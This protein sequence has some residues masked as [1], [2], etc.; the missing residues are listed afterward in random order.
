MDDAPV[1][2][3]D[4]EA[5]ELQEYAL[6]R[7]ANPLEMNGC[8]IYNYSSHVPDYDALEIKTR[9]IP[10]GE[11]ITPFQVTSGWSYIWALLPRK[12]KRNSD[13][14]IYIAHEERYSHYPNFF[15]V[16]VS[17]CGSNLETKNDIAMEYYD[18]D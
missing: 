7:T 6:T 12:L 13:F 2:T 16:K 17:G 5:W 10:D 15:N 1:V 3:E 11:Y 18:Q 8:T 4:T 14:L 9:Q